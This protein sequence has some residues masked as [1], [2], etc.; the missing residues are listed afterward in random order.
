MIKVICIC[1]FLFLLTLLIYYSLAMLY[2]AAEYVYHVIHCSGSVVPFHVQKT[3]RR[4]MC[5]Y[6]MVEVGLGPAT[7]GCVGGGGG[8]RQVFMHTATRS[9]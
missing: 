2:H 1:R 8:V 4:A 7:E 9:S 5:C 3:S 6:P